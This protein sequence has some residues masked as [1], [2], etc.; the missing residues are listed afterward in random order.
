MVYEGMEKVSSFSLDECPVPL[1]L[2]SIVREYMW[3]TLLSSSLR[4]L[5][6]EENAIPSRQTHVVNDLFIF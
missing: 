1:C 6:R 2:C 3:S 4:P 5:L